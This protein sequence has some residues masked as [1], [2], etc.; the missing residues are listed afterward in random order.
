MKKYI[1]FISMAEL[2]TWVRKQSILHEY[3]EIRS[4]KRSRLIDMKCCVMEKLRR[5]DIKMF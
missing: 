5:N 3:W 4:K 1:S 2:G